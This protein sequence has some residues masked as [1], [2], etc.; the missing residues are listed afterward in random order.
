MACD[1]GL[2]TEPLCETGP[3]GDTCCPGKD[4]ERHGARQVSRVVEEGGA[5]Q[6]TVD[7][8]YTYVFLAS[9]APPPWRQDKRNQDGHREP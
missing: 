9:A 4:E 8:A 3:R 6:A 5:Q 2:Y 7:T 1:E